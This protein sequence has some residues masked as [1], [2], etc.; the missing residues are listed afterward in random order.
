MASSA[1]FR[2]LLCFAIFAVALPNA[3]ASVY[4]AVCYTKSQKCCF[5]FHPCGTVI[6]KV[7]TTVDCSFKKCA[8][9]CKPHCIFVPKKVPYQVCKIVKVPHGKICKK[10]KVLH[11]GVFIWKKICKPKF[12]TKRICKTLYR[13]VKKKVCTKKCA[14]VCKIVSATCVK[15]EVLSFPKFCPKLF[16]DK[17]II[18]GSSKSPG[19]KVGKKSKLVKTIKG[20][21]TIKH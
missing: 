20:K 21:R 1:S 7:P 15:I 17:F 12:V 10:I 11:H 6:K 3:L 13:V 16:C 2:S 8:I 4:P 14:K 5:K 18:T 9:L 19:V